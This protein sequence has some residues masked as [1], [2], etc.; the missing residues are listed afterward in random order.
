MIKHEIMA[1]KFKYGSFVT[2]INVD[3]TSIRI[4]T[5]KELCTM[6]G[7]DIGDPNDKI[8]EYMICFATNGKGEANDVHIDGT[9]IL[10]G[11]LYIAFDRNVLKDSWIRI[12]YCLMYFG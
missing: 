10:N 4:Y 7:I 9:T 1:P 2:K 5:K 3:C 11:D 12:N 8:K 6:F